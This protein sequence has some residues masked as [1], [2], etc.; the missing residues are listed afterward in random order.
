LSTTPLGARTRT[1]LISLL[2]GGPLLLAAC[3]D[4]DDETTA[5]PT[6]TTSSSSSPATASSSPSS[7]GSTVAPA[8]GRLVDTSFFSV[9]VPEGW[10]VIESVPDLAVTADDT[11]GLDLISFTMTKTYGK[12]FTLDELARQAL[13]TT[14]WSKQPGIA[15]VTTLAGAPAYHL[16]GPV[17]NGFQAD[18]FGLVHGEENVMVSIETQ[19][20]AATHREIVESVLATWQWK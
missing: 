13:R 12:E 15:P 3:G 5:D 2:V 4:S 17:G 7:P 11:D 10:R 18:A 9:H 1:T 6:P 16:S 14:P 19:G 20:S 8:T